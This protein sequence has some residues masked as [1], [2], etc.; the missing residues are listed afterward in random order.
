LKDF[1]FWIFDEKG[2]SNCV[3]LLESYASSLS[4]K[5]F[6]YNDRFG[7]KI[8]LLPDYKVENL[9]SGEGIVLKKTIEAGGCAEVEECSGYSVYIYVSAYD[10]DLGYKDVADLISKRYAGFSADFVDH[11]V[12]TGICVNEGIGEDAIRRFF[13]MN[14]DSSVIYEAYLRV[15]SFYYA[16]YKVEFDDLIKTFSY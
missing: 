10:N 7:F 9:E 8:E 3:G 5:P 4:D 12:S 11:P 1:S 6:Y 14:E 2:V 13:M 15:P 16:T